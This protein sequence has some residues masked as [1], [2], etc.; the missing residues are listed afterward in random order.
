VNFISTGFRNQNKSSFLLW[1]KLQLQKLLNLLE[2][3][4]KEVFYLGS[5]PAWSNY[6]WPTGHFTKTWQLAGHFQHSNSLYKTTDS[7]HL[8][9]KSGRYVGCKLVSRMTL[10]RSCPDDCGIYLLR[11]CSSWQKPCSAK[12]IVG[13]VSNNCLTFLQS[14]G[15]RP[16]LLIQKF[17]H[18]LIWN[19]ARD[20]SSLWMSMARSWMVQSHSS[21]LASRQKAILPSNFL[22]NVTFGMSF[23]TEWLH[24]K[25][26][27]AGGEMDFWTPQFS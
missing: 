4:E 22:C 15:N 23:T 18:P 7:Q 19:I 6:L 10:P 17:D 13:K 12:Y 8:K 16:L 26:Q 2:M 9:P 20:S 24:S 3:C 5:R 1:S 21:M 27:T 14:S 11:V 25:P